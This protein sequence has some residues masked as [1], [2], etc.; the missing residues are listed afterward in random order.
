MIFETF[1]EQNGSPRSFITDEQ[2]GMLS[3]IDKLIE[4]EAYT[5][6]HLIDSF[7][8]LRNFAKVS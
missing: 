1:I 7:H 6:T 4:D 3:A 5:G 2:S 8:V